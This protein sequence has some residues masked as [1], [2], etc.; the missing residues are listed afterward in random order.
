MGDWKNVQYKDGKLRTNNGGNSHAYSITEQVVGT[1]IDGSDIYEKTF[2]FNTALSLPYNTWVE[3][4]FTLGDGWKIIQQSC[5]DIYNANMGGVNITPYSTNG[6]LAFMN[7]RNN[8]SS[9]AYAIL[10]YIKV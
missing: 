4:D 5:I 1:W 2:V 7:L 10:Q 8:T 9:L 6:K 3:S